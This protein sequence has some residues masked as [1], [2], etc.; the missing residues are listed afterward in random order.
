[1][2]IFSGVFA[3]GEGIVKAPKVN[4][5]QQIEISE[6][7]ERSSVNKTVLSKHNDQLEIT[8]TNEVLNSKINQSD[9]EIKEYIE[10]QNNRLEDNINENL[11]LLF[12]R[13]SGYIENMPKR[14]HYVD[15]Y[16]CDKYIH[17]NRTNTN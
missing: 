2:A 16:I 9:R 10:A 8:P 13:N 14:M 3:W 7:T 5:C 12:S 15:E 11:K 4:E 6:N 1:M 17:T